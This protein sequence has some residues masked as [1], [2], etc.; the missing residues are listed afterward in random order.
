MRLSGSNIFRWLATVALVVNLGLVECGRVTGVSSE[1][2][3]YHIQD[4]IGSTDYSLSADFLV[5]KLPSGSTESSAKADIA[6]LAKRLSPNDYGITV[7][8]AP[9][10][11]NHPSFICVYASRY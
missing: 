2:T 8:N 9:A 6:D 5:K 3:N 4:E 10:A 11:D 1:D 7:E